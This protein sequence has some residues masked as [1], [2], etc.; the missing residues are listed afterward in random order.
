M[1]P[2]HKAV[3]KERGQGT[4][5]YDVFLFGQAFY[6]A[7]QLGIFARLLNLDAKTANGYVDRI[8]QELEHIPASPPVTNLPS[9]EV[10]PMI[11]KT[12]NS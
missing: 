6:V 9:P 8:N 1:K 12:M 2:E 10:W 4:D 3:A 5:V 11:G 7:H